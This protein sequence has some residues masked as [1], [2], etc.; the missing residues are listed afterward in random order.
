MT[1]FH[2]NCEELKYVHFVC[3]SEAHNHLP[4][5]KKLSEIIQH[6]NNQ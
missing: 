5:S 4:A 1:F 6:I 3:L 2:L